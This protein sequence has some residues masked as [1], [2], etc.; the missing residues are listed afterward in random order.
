MLGVVGTV[1]IRRL[2]LLI[3][4]QFELGGVDLFDRLE[5]WIESRRL[6]LAIDTLAVAIPMISGDACRETKVSRLDMLAMH[7]IIKPTDNISDL[8]MNLPLAA[9]NVIHYGNL[10]VLPLST[11]VVDIVQ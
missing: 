6:R 3:L 4:E 11:V 8:E 9:G 2:T 10:V 7:M 5:A 1:Q